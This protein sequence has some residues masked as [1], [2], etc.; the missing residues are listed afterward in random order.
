MMRL[1]GAAFDI[2]LRPLPN[3]PLLTRCHEN[4][5]GEI[6]RPRGTIPGRANP[7]PTTLTGAGSGAAN[8]GPVKHSS[9]IDQRIAIRIRP[10]DSR[11]IWD[12]PRTT[13]TAQLPDNFDLMIPAHDVGF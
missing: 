8:A 3:V 2:A 6:K 5:S 1:Q 7:A 13:L 4:R 9:V 10:L 11:G 12:L